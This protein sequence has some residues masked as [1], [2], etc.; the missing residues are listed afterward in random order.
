MPKL[1]ID[2]NNTYNS[3]LIEMLQLFSQMEITI[4][5]KPPESSIQIFNPI[6]YTFDPKQDGESDTEWG[7]RFIKECVKAKLRFIE[8]I[9]S[10]SARKQAIANLNIT[11]EPLPEDIIT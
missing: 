4:T 2:F 8:Q 3:K 1:E 5:A 9:K 10:D 11:P 6:T 7:Q